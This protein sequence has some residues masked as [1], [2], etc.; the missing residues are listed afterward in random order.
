MYRWCQRSG[1][2]TIVAEESGGVKGTEEMF[3]PGS[4]GMA[5]CDEDSLVICQHP[6]H[7]VVRT[8]FLALNA[9]NGRRFCDLPTNAFDVLV[10]LEPGGRRLNSPNDVIVSQEGDVYFTD[11]IYGFLRKRPGT[12]APL[13]VIEQGAHPDQPYLDELCQSTGAGFKGV[14]RLRPADEPGASLECVTKELD[15]PNGLALSRD[16]N[17]LWVANSCKEGPSWTAFEVGDGTTPFRVVQRIDEGILGES[18]RFGPGL[19]DGFK[20]DKTG[21]IWSTV[22]GG[23]VVI[24]P[25][26][27]RLITR[28]AMGINTSNVQFGG[29]G[30]VFITGLGH[31]WMVE[32]CV[33]Q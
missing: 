24:D 4:N 30:E 20:I 28:I 9:L 12:Y 26:Q 11:P 1:K 29:N 5:L 10:S 18:L 14:F 32:Q 33:P 3:E 25:E 8:T 17:I 16:E 19:S 15:R 7:R 22:P 31:V 23:V 6:S 2:V 21:L 13:N 27:C